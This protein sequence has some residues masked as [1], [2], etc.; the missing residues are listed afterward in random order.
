MMRDVIIEQIDSQKNF[1]KSH[2]SKNIPFRI[3]QLKALK[4][5]IISREKLI[6]E[7]LWHDLHKSYEE[8]YL[9]EISLVIQEINYHIKKLKNWAKPKRVS[10][11]IYLWP[12]Q[13]KLY[14]EPLGL[15]LIISPWNYPFQ[16][17]MS[18]LIGAISAGCTVI[19]KPSPDAPKTSK[20]M[21][22]LI[23]DTF[24]KNYI[25]L[26]EGGIEVNQILLQQRF[27]IIFFTGSTQVGKIVSKAAAEFLTPVVLE[28]GGKSPCIVDKNADIKLAAKRI[29]WGKTLNAGQTCIAPDYV[30]VHLSIKEK[31]IDEIK[32]ALT[33]MFGSDLKNSSFYP[34]IIH[35]KAFT[36]LQNLMQNGQIRMGG[37]SS[38][39]DKFIAP[40]LLDNINTTDDIMQ[41]EIFG[42]L[43]PL[44]TFE[45]INEPLTHINNGEKPLALYYFGSNEIAQ[46]I[47]HKTSSGGACINDTIMHVSN[48]NLPF[49]GVGQSGQGTYHGKKSFD[50]F[51]HFKSVVYTPTWIDLPFKY[52]PFSYFKFIKKLI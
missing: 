39:S 21:A 11:P 41:E 38:E 7:A 5:A 20:V 50:T 52:A 2:Q 29:I 43:L 10:T 37:E 26:I 19:L 48:H 25:S 51:S 18:P 31:L 32:T 24:P 9:T 23:A 47:L 34:R 1:F 36:R 33:N 16:L 13:S 4:L 30:Y 6:T 27:D 22:E 45:D 3:E 28:L 42:P 15:A 44:L 17:T 40:T 8:A 12:S 14:P 35:H 46:D 49:G